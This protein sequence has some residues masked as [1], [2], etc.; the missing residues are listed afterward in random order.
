MKKYCESC[1]IRIKE[2]WIKNLLEKDPKRIW[3]PQHVMP[4][5]SIK[6]ET[7]KWIDDNYYY[8]TAVC[9]LCK[10]EWELEEWWYSRG[11][12]IK[13]HPNDYYEIIR[14]CEYSGRTS[15]FLGVFFNKTPPE[16]IMQ[17][18]NKY[19]SESAIKLDNLIREYRKQGLCKYHTD[20]FSLREM[21]LIGISGK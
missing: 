16:D 12:K 10:K 20:N 15:A 11:I 1:D 3:F 9:S 18:E 17:L 19:D 2:E 6:L 5:Y 13:I 4:L 8:V 7:T 21:A 14:C